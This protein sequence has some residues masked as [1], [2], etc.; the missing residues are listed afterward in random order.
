VAFEVENLEFTYTRGTSLLRIPK[1]S[2]AQGERVF[3]YGP[4]GSGKSTLLQLLAGVLRP[5]QGK[6]E[7][8]GSYDLVRLSSSGLDAFRGSHVGYIF[9]QFNLLPHLSVRENILLPIK[10]SRQR[11]ARLQ[12]AGRSEGAEVER[13][14]GELGIG[15]LLSKY[16]AA[17]SVGQ[18]QRVAAARALLASPEILIA[19]E[20]TSAL[21]TD[22]RD[23]F[24]KILLEEAEKTK[25]TLIFVSH[26]RSLEK[27]FTKSY[28]IAD[29]RVKA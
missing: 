7:A 12:K 23:A 19:D 16:P 21:D 10:I 4:S 14:A 15:D 8:L 2:I 9:Q 1:L 29:W 22:L 6:L 20:P 25:A 24:M 3:L 18:Q 17:L 26:D 5:R 28:S 27:H 13:L 11:R